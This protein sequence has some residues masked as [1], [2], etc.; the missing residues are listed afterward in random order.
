MRGF[1]RQGE[2]VAI[3]SGFCQPTPRILR[4]EPWVESMEWKGLQR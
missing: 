4:S 2:R 3:D 1:Y